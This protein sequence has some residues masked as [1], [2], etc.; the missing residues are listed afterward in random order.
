M[1]KILLTLV[2][3]FSISAMAQ[4]P[5][6][7]MIAYCSS[8]EHHGVD[9]DVFVNQSTKDIT[10]RATG[11][12]GYPKDYVVTSMKTVFSD[13]GM[14]KTLRA[15]L[16]EQAF[17]NQ[18]DDRLD[19]TVEATSQKNDSKLSLTVGKKINLNINGYNQDTWCKPAQGE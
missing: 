3:L 2:T 1:K 15:F 5:A 6:G 8:V 17:K 9:L 7:E 18:Q 16:L 14:S 12:D 11:G 13:N 4:D 10:I 19:I